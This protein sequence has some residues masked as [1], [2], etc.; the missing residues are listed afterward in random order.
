MIS[1]LHNFVSEMPT[2]SYEH[3]NVSNSGEYSFDFRPHTLMCGI[4]ISHVSGVSDF[5]NGSLAVIKCP[6]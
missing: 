5:I 2:M 6:V 1:S 3:I 4:L